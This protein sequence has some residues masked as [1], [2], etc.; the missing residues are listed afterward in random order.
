MKYPL[1][2]MFLTFCTLK[3]VIVNDLEEWH[4]DT[5]RDAAR[6]ILPDENTTLIFPAHLLVL[7]SQITIQG[8]EN[9]GSFCHGL[10]FWNSI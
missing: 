4:E 1:T 2:V 3:L 7:N 9:L 6:Y 8:S 10:V 5:P